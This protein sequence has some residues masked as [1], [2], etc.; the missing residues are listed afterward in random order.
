M[1]S[2]AKIPTALVQHV[3]TYLRLREAHALTC[4]A[5]IFYRVALTTP[6]IPVYLTLNHQAYDE[7]TGTLLPQ[8]SRLRPLYLEASPQQITVQALAQLAAMTSLRSLAMNLDLKG[9][10]SSNCLL[11]L[12]T[13]TALTALEVRIGRDAKLPIRRLSFTMFP[14][15]T[16][17]RAD[18]AFIE[19]IPPL[20]ISLRCGRVAERSWSTLMLHPHLTA[21]HCTVPTVLPRTPLTFVGLTTMTLRCNCASTFA[22]SLSEISTLRYLNVYGGKFRQLPWVGPT[23][24]LTELDV[25][26]TQ[27]S[28]Q[29]RNSL[30]NFNIPTIHYPDL[31]VS[32]IQ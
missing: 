27:L 14:T 24:P 32:P 6:T 8:V 15:L 10:R 31:L 21:L 20:L 25:R 23:S 5:P 28:E 7:K 3:F 13:L 11:P 4:A 12:S 26:E 9:N 2:L 18:K 29:V 30:K 1:P 19:H 17:L 22:R 16:H